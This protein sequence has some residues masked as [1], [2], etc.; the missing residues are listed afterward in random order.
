VVPRKRVVQKVLCRGPFDLNRSWNGGGNNE[1]SLN[2]CKA[3]KCDGGPLDSHGPLGHTVQKF[4][5]RE[6]VVQNT[7]NKS[8]GGCTQRSAEGSRNCA[9]RKKKGNEAPK[10]K[11]E[12]GTKIPRKQKEKKRKRGKMKKKGGEYM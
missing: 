11:R 7:S 4:R 6:Q 2:R 5:R 10:L 3:E 12:K 8:V 1:E 9:G